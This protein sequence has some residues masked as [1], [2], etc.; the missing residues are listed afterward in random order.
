GADLGDLRGEGVAQP[1]R[2]QAAGAGDRAGHAFS[3]VRRVQPWS[4]QPG[5]WCPSVQPWP[6]RPSSASTRHRARGKRAG[7]PAGE[8]TGT[9]ANASGA[10]VAVVPGQWSRGRAGGSEASKD[11][12]AEKPSRGPISPPGGMVKHRQ[13]SG[14][15]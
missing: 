15:P 1:G 5:G 9:C 12:S 3:S 2:G 4:R 11:G 10:T 14:K 13:G 7:R 6:V 8:V